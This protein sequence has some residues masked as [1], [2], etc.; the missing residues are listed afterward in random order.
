MTHNTTQG[1]NYRRTD[2]GNVFIERRNAEE[3]GFR[4]GILNVNIE[5]S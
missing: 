4:A 5:N 1:V 2:H 3:F